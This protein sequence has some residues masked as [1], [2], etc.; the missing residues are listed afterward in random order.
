MSDQDQPLTP[1]ASGDAPGAGQEAQDRHAALAAEVTARIEAVAGEIDAD[2]EALT[3]AA[4]TQRA[5][6]E[7][8]DRDFDARE[9]ALYDEAMARNA[10]RAEEGSRLIAELVYRSQHKMGEAA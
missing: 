10:R 2:L 5:E 3:K 6:T 9:A 4:E 7:A 1:D 8:A